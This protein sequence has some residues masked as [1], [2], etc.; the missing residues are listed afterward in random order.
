MSASSATLGVRNANLL[1]RHRSLSVGVSRS[2]RP[3]F[4]TPLARRVR[5]S[6]L[7]DGIFFVLEV[8]FHPTL[9]SMGAD[10]VLTSRHSVKLG[11]LLYHA[12]TSHLRLAVGALLVYDVTRCATLGNIELT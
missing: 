10:V 9:P 6:G 4:G 11:E 2:S 5:V 7:L 8:R 1:A 12:V 3:G